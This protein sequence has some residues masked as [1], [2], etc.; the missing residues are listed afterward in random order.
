MASYYYLM[1]QLPYLSY[2]Q[3]PSMPSSAFKTMAEAF[4]SK[5]DTDLFNLLSLDPYPESANDDNSTYSEKA[6]STGCGFIDKWREWERT[7]RLHLAKNRAIK[8]KRDTTSMAEPPFYPTDLAVTASKALGGDLSPLEGE[9]VIDKA[10]W[11]AIENLSG[12]DY[13][14]RNNVFAYFLKLLLLER[15]LSFNAERGFSEYKS[16][17]SSIIKSTENAG[18]PT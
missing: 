12:N 4:M 15:R 3:R 14:H 18:E 5:G 17:Y 13:F 6:P 10:R 11:A 9:I 1:A 2:E 16:L 8:L 7:L